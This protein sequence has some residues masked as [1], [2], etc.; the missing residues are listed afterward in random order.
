MRRA[1]DCDICSG[2]VLG[3][4]LCFGLFDILYILYI[5]LFPLLT[6]DELIEIAERDNDLQAWKPSSRGGQAASQRDSGLTEFSSS[7]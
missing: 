2:K 7:R 3:L 4:E 5:R 6:L 1:L